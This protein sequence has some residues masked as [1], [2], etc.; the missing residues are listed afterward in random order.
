MFCVSPPFLL[1]SLQLFGTAIENLGELADHIIAQGDV[2]TIVKAE[3]GEV[4]GITADAPAAKRAKK[5][6][7]KDKAG[8]AAAAASAAAV[9]VKMGNKR[10]EDQQ[11]R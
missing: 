8:G 3:G 6:K 4:A 10:D 5:S 1:L 11:R 2:A 9:Q 7:G